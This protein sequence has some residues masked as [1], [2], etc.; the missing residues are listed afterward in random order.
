[1]KREEILTSYKNDRYSLFPIKYN[2]IWQMYKNHKNTFWTVEEIDMSIDK[3]EW[4][5]LSQAEKYFIENILAFFAQSDTIVL[6]NLITNFCQEVTIPE[7][8]FFYSFQAMIENIHSEAYSLMIE[9]FIDDPK[10]K[11]DLFNAMEKV[12]CVQ[13][14]AKWASRCRVGSG[15]L[16]RSDS[17]PFNGDG[18][19]VASRNPG[20]L[21]GSAEALPSQRTVVVGVFR[22]VGPRS[23]LGRR[24]GPR[25]NHSGFGAVVAQKRRGPPRQTVPA[26][27]PDVSRE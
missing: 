2:D 20:D 6:D 27:L 5:T 18:V 10:R 22:K 13:K 15:R 26:H 23:L 12:P 16:G 11:N 19:D 8:R 4:N 24:H 3:K 1:M 9:N 25:E 14:K 21:Q 17:E 7:A